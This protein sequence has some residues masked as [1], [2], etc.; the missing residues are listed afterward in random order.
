MKV[1]ATIKIVLL[2]MIV[3]LS[4]AAQ[5]TSMAPQKP[6]TRAQILALLAGDVPSSRVTMLVEQR[7]IDFTPNDAYL[8]QVQKSGGEEDLAKALQSAHVTNAAS[9]VTTLRKTADETS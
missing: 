8:G 1:Q 4:A 2:A 5:T 6:L 9:A 7:G 3:V